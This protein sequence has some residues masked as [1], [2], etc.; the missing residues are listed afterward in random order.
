MTDVMGKGSARR[1]WHALP[2]QEGAAALTET[3]KEDWHVFMRHHGH[4]L[5]PTPLFRR[6][7]PK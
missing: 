7:H 5:T 2:W 4:H 6:H 1:A 3:K